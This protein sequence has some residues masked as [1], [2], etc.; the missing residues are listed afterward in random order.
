MIAEKEFNN[1][2]K[3]LRFLYAINRAGGIIVA[4]YCDDPY[5]NEYLNQRFNPQKGGLM[6]KNDKHDYTIKLECVDILDDTHFEEMDDALKIPSEEIYQ[7]IIDTCER[8]VENLIEQYGEKEWLYFYTS[9]YRVN[10][11]FKGRM[12]RAWSIGKYLRERKIG[13]AHV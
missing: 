1:V 9:Y 3:A 5:D 2:K 7:E 8:I 10:L 4:W 12:I 11:Y 13:R 6:R